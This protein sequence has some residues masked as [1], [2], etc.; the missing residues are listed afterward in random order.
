MCIKKS[1]FLWLLSLSLGLCCLAASPSV[2]ELLDEI[3]YELTI[4]ETLISDWKVLFET[5]VNEREVLAKERLILERDMM[6]RLENSLMDSKILRYDF[7]HVSN[8]YDNLLRKQKTHKFWVVGAALIGIGLG[9]L[10]SLTI[11]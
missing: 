4:Q 11:H 7:E 5:M 6:N 10:G 2:S 3:D 1:L 8:A 9:L